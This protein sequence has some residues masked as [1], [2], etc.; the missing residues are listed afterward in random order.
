MSYEQMLEFLKTKRDQFIMLKIG[1]VTFFFGLGLGLGL[2]IKD[3][4][5]SDAWVPLFIFTMT[6][7]GFVI[8][9]L[10]ARKLEK[11]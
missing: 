10:F 7:V 4:S 6:G 1:I 11:N 8:A 5:D 3:Y 9:Q 2:F